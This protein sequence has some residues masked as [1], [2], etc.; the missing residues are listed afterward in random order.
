VEVVGGLDIQRALLVTRRRLVRTD[1]PGN[2]V[3]GLP[4]GLDGYRAQVDLHVSLLLCCCAV[5]R[6]PGAVRPLT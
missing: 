6:V 4:Q 5:L 1:T 3:E 2:V